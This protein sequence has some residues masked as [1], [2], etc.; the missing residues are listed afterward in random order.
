MKV[1]NSGATVE[2]FTEAQREHMAAGISTRLLEQ[3][4]TGALDEALSVV[5]ML[6]ELGREELVPIWLKA[7]LAIV[8]ITAS[9]NSRAV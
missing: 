7:A 1:V 4:G 5:S 6:V 8:R 9:R 2:Q 3:Y